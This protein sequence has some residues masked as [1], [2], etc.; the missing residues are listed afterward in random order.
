VVAPEY[1]WN[2]YAGVDVKGK[3]VV[4]LI[5]DPGNEDAAPDDKFF[6]GRAMT[7]YGRW[8][9]K[10]EE[11]ARQGAAAAIIVH[12]DRPAA[13]GWQVVRNSNGAAKMW[14]E[15]AD[16]NR[17]MVPLQG[18]MTLGTAKELFARAG[19]DY[20]AQKA[21][22]NRRGFKAVG[23]AGERLAAIAHS[24]IRHMKTRN[25]IGLIPGSKRPGDVFMYSAHWDH[26]GRKD[27]IEGAD[28][29]YNGA[30]DNGMGIA[31]VL[32]L[33]EV[34]AH[35]KRPQRSIVFAFWTLEEQGLLGAEYF[36]AHPLWPR[37][38]I[39]GVINLDGDMELPPAR[40]ISASGTGQ[41]E[42]EDVLADAL[43][44]QHRVLSPDPTPERGSFFRSDHFSLAKVGIPAISPGAGIDLMQGGAVTGQ[45][46]KDAYTADRYHQPTDEWRA[47]WDLSGRVLDLR[48]YY[49]AGDTL[50]NGERWPNY[51]PGSE[52]RALRD[53]DRPPH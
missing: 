39:V 22:A 27:N 46:L 40:N 21:A 11:A 9:Y 48:A 38:N 20:A 33:A 5:N 32:E 15:A 52:F 13:Y 49:V 36:G 10:F 35:E 47:D 45:K 26:L 7:Y 37:R 4:I 25:V 17:S 14:L 19:L 24:S 16:R 29:I 50:A 41:S 28:K 23:L 6:K 8:T 53:K 30:V 1:G 51:Y 31:E 18:W 12:E 42:L 43:A 34:F 2:D 3:T 44:T